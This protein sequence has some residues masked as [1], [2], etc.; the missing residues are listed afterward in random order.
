MI[1]KSAAFLAI[2]FVTA[3]LAYRFIEMPA[4]RWIM[5]FYKNG[6]MLPALTPASKTPEG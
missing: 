4:R 1:W 2:L 6:M 5:N 3:W